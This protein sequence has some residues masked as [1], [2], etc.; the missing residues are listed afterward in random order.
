[1]PTYCAPWPGNRNAT[2]ALA[3][4]RSVVSDRGALPASD[5]ASTASSDVAADDRA[6]DAR[7][8]AAHLQREGD[9]GQVEVGVFAQVRGQARPQRA[10]AAA[11]VRAESSRS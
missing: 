6:R 2:D 3:A 1:M 4:G 5:R 11:G 10:R 8:P 7:T 9:V